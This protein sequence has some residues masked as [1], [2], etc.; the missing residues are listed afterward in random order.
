VLGG[1]ADLWALEVACAI[2]D[3]SAEVGFT[4]PKACGPAPMAGARLASA[5][6]VDWGTIAGISP[7]LISGVAAACKASAWNATGCGEGGCPP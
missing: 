7:C 4:V 1:A 3:V 5:P 6:W 2:V